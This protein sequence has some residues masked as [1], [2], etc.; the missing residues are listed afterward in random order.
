MRP[1][2]CRR[3]SPT[4][5]RSGEPVELFDVEDPR[6]LAPGDLPARIAEWY[7]E[8]GSVIPATRAAFVR[9]IIESLAEAFATTVRTA[10]ELAGGRI[11]TIHIVGGG[12]PEHACCASAPRTAGHPRARRPGRGDGDRQCARAG[13]RA[14]MV[15]ARCL[16]RPP[17]RARGLGIPAAAIRTR[18]CLSLFPYRPSRAA[19]NVE[20]WANDERTRTRAGRGCADRRQRDHR[21]AAGGRQPRRGGHAQNPRP[22]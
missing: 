13:A 4:P 9:A 6:F 20:E 11:D 3:S 8:N 10:A 2:T 18:L 17:A 21:G 5:P 19:P 15:R 14:G 12:A 7:R 22:G 1:S 16:A